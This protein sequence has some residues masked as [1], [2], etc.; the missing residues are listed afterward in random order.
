MPTDRHLN[1]ELHKKKNPSRTRQGL[2]HCRDV[3]E[4]H[5][6]RSHTP[7]GKGNTLEPDSAQVNCASSDA[8]VQALFSKT[9]H[10]DRVTGLDRN[11]ED[12]NLKDTGAKEKQEG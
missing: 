7:A 2:Q 3:G 12:P 11:K 5:R 8:Q 10:S 4:C 6:G 1:Q 9:Q